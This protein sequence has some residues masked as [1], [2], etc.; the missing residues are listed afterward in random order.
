LDAPDVSIIIPTISGRESV[1]RRAVK[2]VRED[3]LSV[4]LIIAS[5][6]AAEQFFDLETS[7]PEK[8]FSFVSH[9][10]KGNAAE[11][12]NMALEVARGS[13]VAFLDD[14]DE[15]SEGKLAFQLGLMNS[16][17]ARW[18][19]TNYF[20]C[21]TGEGQGCIPFS[22]RSMLRRKLD[23]GENCA[24]ATPTVM[25]ERNLLEEGRLRFNTDLSL[26]ED[27][28]LW[29]RLLELSP[30]LYIPVPLTKVHRGPNASFLAELR[31]S[32]HPSVQS[33]ILGSFA[34]LQ[35][36][37]ADRIDVISRRVRFVF[38]PGSPGR[39]P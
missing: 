31:R 26:R 19:F 11:N 4:E 39:N 3:S 10:G 34:S 15:F 16:C 8:R 33:R 18:A 27:I 5:T 6:N 14:D 23:L 36:R 22:A 1:L 25:V 7:F 9:G 28:D 29:V 17:G 12:R 2:S 13:Y 38:P 24:I 21:G 37:L 35:R 30:A 20:L 32:E